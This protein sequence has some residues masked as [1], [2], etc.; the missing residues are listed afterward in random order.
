MLIVRYGFMAVTFSKF[1]I[2]ME[3][4]RIDKTCSGPFVNLWM[5]GMGWIGFLRAVHGI[6]CMPESENPEPLCHSQPCGG[7]IERKVA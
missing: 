2:I 6:Y 7:E 3:K 4:C 1:C 5:D